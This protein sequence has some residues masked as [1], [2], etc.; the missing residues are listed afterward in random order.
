MLNAFCVGLHAACVTFRQLKPHNA[1]VSGWTTFALGLEL[2]AATLLLV[3]F[4][5]TVQFT[6]NFGA[7]DLNI[8]GLG[9]GSMCGLST[10]C[11][12]GAL[13]ACIRSANG[14]LQ[15]HL[16]SFS[17]GDPLIR[18]FGLRALLLTLLFGA[19]EGAPC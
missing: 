11:K 6:G 2:G 5:F 13:L 18:V 4:V 14:V 1:Q 12:L 15:I 19:A 10:D 7:R 16:A 9:P 17:V 3:V 8:L